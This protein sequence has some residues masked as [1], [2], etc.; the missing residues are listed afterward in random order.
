[1]MASKGFAKRVNRAGA[2]IAKDDAYRT[3]DQLISW[4]GVSIQIQ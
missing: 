1:M 4:P 2:N 3:D